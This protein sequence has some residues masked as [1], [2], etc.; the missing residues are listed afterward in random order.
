MEK[1]TMNDFSD[2]PLAPRKNNIFLHPGFR[3]GFI[4]A[5]IAILFNLMLI[6]IYSGDTRGD[7]I[8]WF[9]QVI[10]YFIV[11]RGAA[12]SQYN[13]NIR[14]GGYEYLR[15]VKAAGLGAGLTASVLVWVYIIIRGVIRD[16]FGVFILVEPF[17]LCIGIFM[18]VLIAITL[19]A[20]GGNSIAK[21][22]SVDR[23]GG[24]F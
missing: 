12:E 13:S 17:S 15:G 3:F 11:S 16:A 14:R 7:G 22:Y 4:G 23:L 6:L 21:K 19:G 1:T 24:S 20:W 2:A 18:D 10:I 5:V 8:A 9:F